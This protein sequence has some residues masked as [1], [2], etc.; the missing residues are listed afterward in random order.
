M[1]RFP[2]NPVFPERGVILVRFSCRPIPNPQSSIS[3]CSANGEAAGTLGRAVPG[4]EAR[5]VRESQARTVCKACP[6]LHEC[7][8]WARENREYGFWGGE[9]EEE[10]AAAGYRVD[11]PVGRVA[12]LG[13][14]SRN[15]VMLEV[16]KVKAAGG[17]AGRQIEMVIRDSKGQPQEAARVARELVNTD[18][19]ELLID[20]EAS[21][22]ASTVSSARRPM[23][24]SWTPSMPRWRASVMRCLIRS[25]ATAMKSS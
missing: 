17:L 22:G 23:R 9:S 15:A 21:S 10:R 6:A 18:G 20:A 12:Q 16:D 25:S 8:D 11:M 24:T 14:S 13:T 4:Y 1:T 2:F 19:C 7:R 3:C 5:V